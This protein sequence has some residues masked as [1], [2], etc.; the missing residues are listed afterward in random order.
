MERLVNVHHNLIGLKKLTAFDQLRENMQKFQALQVKE[1]NKEE[2]KE[3]EILISS[4]VNKPAISTYYTPNQLQTAYGMN[5]IPHSTP[6]GS[7]ITV[8]VVI[9][10]S[11]NKLQ[12]DLNSYCNRYGLPLTTLT[13]YNMNN[14]PNSSNTAFTTKNPDWALECCLD[15]QMIHTMAPGASILVVQAVSASFN[16]LNNAISYAN[17]HAD[18]ISMSWGASESPS[19]SSEE[20]YFSNPH[21]CYLASSGDDNY[22]SYPSSSPHVLSVGGTTLFL[23]SNG[24]RSSEET[25]SYSGCGSSKIFRCPIYQNGVVSNSYRCIPDIS[26]CGNPSSGVVVYCSQYGG[27]FVVG[28]SSLS[29]PLTAGILAVANQFRKL[30]NK[31]LLNTTQISQSGHVQTFFYKTLYSNKNLYSQNFYDVKKGLDGAF[32]SK[33]G[34]DIATGLGSINANYLCQSLLNA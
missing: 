28:G 14:S 7:G 11:Y 30:A 29:C 8:A 34:Y 20:I 6:L 32:V 22:V 3:E 21:I 1:E 9:A 2:N 23:N 13:I 12:N 26:L 31:P 16:D 4:F 17:N 25:W 18:I 24:T 19:D 10:Y 15:I 33:T 5:L 27:W